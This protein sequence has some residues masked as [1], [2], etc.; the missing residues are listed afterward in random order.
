[1][2]H[3]LSLDG[4]MPSQWPPP[5]IRLIRG[6]DGGYRWTDPDGNLLLHGSDKKPSP[7]PNKAIAER[8][9]EVLQNPDGWIQ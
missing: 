8:I 1:M 3:Q 4:F 6:P 9:R 7:L 2:P 5:G